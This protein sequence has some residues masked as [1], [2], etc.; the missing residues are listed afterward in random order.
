[1]EA[2]PQWSACFHNALI[3]Y[4]DGLDSHPLNTPDQKTVVTIEDLIGEDEIWFMATSAVMFKNGLM[5]Y[6]DWFLRSSSGDIPRYV[7]LAKQGPI[8]YLPE[9]MSVYRKNRGGASFKDHYRDARFLYNR[10]QMYEGINQ[11]LGGKYA[12]TLKR[13]IARYY[14]MMLDARQYQKSYYRRAGMALKYIY[15]GK[16]DTETAKEIVRDYVLPKWMMKLYSF[17]ALL[18]HRLKTAK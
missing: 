2:Q 5:Y 11:E 3:T 16:P 7:I 14:R 12:K 15:W 18:P 13:N 4:E 9:T 1:M 6:P 17:F 10:I 8:G